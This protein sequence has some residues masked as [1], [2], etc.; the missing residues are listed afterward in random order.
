MNR[1]P[2]FKSTEWM[3]E[4]KCKDSDPA[5][6]FPPDSVGVDRAVR[7]C[8]GGSLVDRCVVIEE[9]LAYAINNYIDDGVW[10]GTSQRERRKIKK[11][12]RNEA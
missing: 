4:A 1:D 11:A 8:R 5:F 7:F 12:W 2:S 3:L 6:F 9:C 10:G